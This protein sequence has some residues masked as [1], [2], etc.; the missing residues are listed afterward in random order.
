[1]APSSS[2]PDHERDACATP[3]RRHPGRPTPPGKSSFLQQLEGTSTSVRMAHP[4]SEP[5]SLL[6][7]RALNTRPRSSRRWPAKH[8]GPDTRAQVHAFVRSGLH[9]PLNR[10]VAPQA[11][12]K[13][14]TWSRSALA[15]GRKSK[16]VCQSFVLLA[17]GLKDLPDQGY[18]LYLEASRR[19]QHRGGGAV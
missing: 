19:D 15:I 1:M 10:F 17:P 5:A 4:P 9:E 12:W 2:W 3:C 16:V 14:G 13:P 7:G 6:P 8:E 11:F 18:R